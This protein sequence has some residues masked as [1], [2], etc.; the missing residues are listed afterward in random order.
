MTK[1]KPI[2]EFIL[3]LL[4]FLFHFKHNPDEPGT[5]TNLLPHGTPETGTSP[6]PPLGEERDGTVSQT[7]TED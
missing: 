7:D 4:N 6:A 2:I 5:D 3:A 1:I